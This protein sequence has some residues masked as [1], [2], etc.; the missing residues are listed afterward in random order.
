[1][2]LIALLLFIN[3]GCTQKT[4]DAPTDRSNLDEKGYL[5]PEGELVVNEKGSNSIDALTISFLLGKFNTFEN[6][7]FDS[8]WLLADEIS[9]VENKWVNYDA[10]GKGKYRFQYS[11]DSSCVRILVL[12]RVGLNFD[13]VVENYQDWQFIRFLEYGYLGG[14]DE[15]VSRNTSAR[16][17]V[18]D[19]KSKKLLIFVNDDESNEGSYAGVSSVSSIMDLDDQLYPQK[20]A[21]FTEGQVSLIGK[22]NYNDATFAD[23]I[24]FYKC[25]NTLSLSSQTTIK[26]VEDVLYHS[27]LSFDG[28]AKATDEPDM[29]MPLWYYSAKIPPWAE[30]K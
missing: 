21:T 14:I 15:N 11:A 10:N 4:N 8:N 2:P 25:E 22:I 17:A 7:D 12:R 18:F 24:H 20:I 27:S 23:S 28:S 29:R 1:M 30:S 16:C 13:L 19:K 3:V 5:K 9:I 26:E 6:C